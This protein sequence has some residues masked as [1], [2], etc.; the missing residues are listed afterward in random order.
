VPAGKAAP[1]RAGDQPVTPYRA[2]VPS[3]PPR[4][5]QTSR[6]MAGALRAARSVERDA[7]LLAVGERR[8]RGPL[9][10]LERLGVEDVAHLVA[11]RLRALELLLE[12]AAD[13]LVDAALLAILRGPAPRAR[14]RVVGARR[15]GRP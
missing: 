6:S 9:E 8:A 10:A 15:R 2:S 5:I 14:R 13:E 3:A 1:R 7:T 4:A 11:G 12:A